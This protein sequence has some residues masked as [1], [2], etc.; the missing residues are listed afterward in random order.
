M[1]KK[2]ET[3]SVDNNVIE[4]IASKNNISLILARVLVNR[5]INTDEKIQKFLYP[6]LDDL[7]D[8]YMLNDMDVAVKRINQAIEQKEKITIY[9]DYDVDG[10][11]SITI[12]KRFLD[13]N[14][15]IVDY[16]LPNRLEEG[17]GLNN[18]ALQKIKDKGTTLLITVDCGISAYDEIEFAK[19][20]GIDVI[21]TDHHECPAVLPNTFAV[22][23]PKRPDSTYPFNSLAGVGVTFKLIHA[24]SISMNLPSESYLK[25]LDIVCLGTVADIVPLVDENRVIVKY[26]LEYIKKTKNIGLK[27]LINISGY[28]EID[29]SAISFGLAPRINA[30]GR[31]GEAD[32]AVE[33]LL[34]S[35]E[36]IAADIANKLQ[37]KNKERQE[38]EKGIMA[39]A[40]AKIEE[41]KMYNDNAI[42]VG[43]ENWYHGV[44]GIVA[45]KIT[46]LYYKPSILVCFD[47][48]IGK[49]SGRS[50]DGF[51]LH[52]ALNAA[53]EHLQKFGGHE[54]AIGLSVEKN[55]FNDFKDAIV[56]YA[57][58]KIT[59]EFLPVIKIDAEVST[60]EVSGKTIQDLKLLEPYGENNMPPIFMYKNIKVDSVRTLSNDKHL[61]LNVKDGNI[62]F[63]AIAFNM[64]DKKDSIRMGDKVDILFHLEI[65]KFNG[66]ETIQLNVKDIK[67]SL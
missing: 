40:V 58:E 50:I 53:S 16:Y 11:T 2:W 48:E 8:P 5:G 21:V 38:V 29:S 37:E 63:D 43:S 54:M 22:I 42:V 57:N 9:G 19:S 10:I 25:Y 1:T 65:N 49:G 47:D 46:D 36:N 55:K 13:E 44:I 18:N 15:I 67:K 24:L 3:Y 20:L 62:V 32:I 30:C 26:G 6:S 4:E 41:A 27:A 33:M 7:N 35:D 34:T 61:K 52:E 28:S 23:D 66:R 39:D 12:L 56:K 14:G 60:K 31:M 64:G 17:Y 51:D 45:S 59:E